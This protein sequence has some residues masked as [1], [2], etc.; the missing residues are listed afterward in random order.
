[1]AELE[2]RLVT[3]SWG[4]LPRWIV[5][6]EERHPGTA[7]TVTSDSAAAAA[8]DGAWARFDVPFPPLEDQTMPG[9]VAHL[10]TPR[11]F[12]IVLV[13]R[14]GFAVAHARDESILDAK[15]G[16]RHVQ[17]RTKAGGWS[18]QRF[19]RRRDQQA[20]EAFDAAADHTASIVGAAASSLNLLVLG[21]DRAGVE[22]V[23]ADRRLRSLVDRDRRWI[24]VSGDPR[25]PALEAA[26]TEV[27]SV[28]IS[29]VD[30]TSRS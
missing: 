2:P 7:W 1:M 30:P 29:I 24:S 5:R 6:F 17:G 19:A 20:R 15:V 21:G 16:R 27:R 13:R 4:R 18:Q 9:L 26:L 14:G 8:P 25:R 3:V 10:V 11:T 28:Q 22:Q 12:G 23:L